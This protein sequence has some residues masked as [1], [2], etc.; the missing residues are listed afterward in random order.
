MTIKK[1][2]VRTPKMGYLG[3][4]LNGGY[5]EDMG[6]CVTEATAKKDYQYYLKVENWPDPNSQPP[7]ICVGS[8]QL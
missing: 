5:I 8:I 7:G 1:T 2:K 3:F 4:T 6:Y